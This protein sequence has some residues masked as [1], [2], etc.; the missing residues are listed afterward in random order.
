MET[1]ENIKAHVLVID[2]EI[3]IQEIICATLEEDGYECVAAASVDAALEQ[4][5]AQPFDVVFTDIKM[6]GRSGTELLGIIK[7]KYPDIVVVMITAVDTAQMAIE[8]VRM[9]AYDY[10]VKPFHLDQVLVAADRA[11]EK[12][13]LEGASREYQKYLEQT[14]EERSAETR[15]LFYSMTQVLIRLLEIKA[16]FSVGHPA[17]VA[18]MARYVARELKMTEDGIR[19]VYLAALLHD[20]GMIA[21]EGM[22]LAKQGSLTPEEHR[23]IQEHTALAQDV[24]K[25]IM[26]D[27]EVLKYIRHHH[28]R[29]DGTGYPDGLKGKIIP[30]G[31]RIIAAV[32]AFEAMTQNRPYRRA[33]TPEQAINELY[34]CADSQFDRQ[35]VTVF[36][37]LYD[38][39]FR[40]FSDYTLSQP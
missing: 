40:N 26:D 20:I 14:A 25:P 30:L 16:P 1:P 34:R 39:V 2:D 32:E 13:R 38:R 29:Y 37:E 24:L 28:E 17:R 7:S 12:K 33:L 36:A 35:V 8:T 4:L 15:R 5:A 9:G 27:E 31:A 23:Q 18:E 21:V 19:K 6:P 11:L 3:Y 10:I 22:V